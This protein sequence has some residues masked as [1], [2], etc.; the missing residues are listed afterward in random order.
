MYRQARLLSA[1]RI[2]SLAED[3]FRAEQD[4]VDLSRANAHPSPPP[5]LSEDER[6][7][8]GFTTASGDHICGICISDGPIALGESIYNLGCCAHEF[9]MECISPW[10]NKSRLCPTCKQEIQVSL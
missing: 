10:L 4:V 3:H 9:H 5:P 2:A 7:A 6:S 1:Q 8:L